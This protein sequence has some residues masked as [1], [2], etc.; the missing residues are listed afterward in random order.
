[1]RVERELLV[2][3]RRHLLVLLLLLERVVDLFTLRLR[4]RPVVRRLIGAERVRFCISAAEP[5]WTGTSA[6]ARVVLVISTRV[7]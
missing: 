6:A 5:R 3:Q 2:C 1:V 4:M 7:A